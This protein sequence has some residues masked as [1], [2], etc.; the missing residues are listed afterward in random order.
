MKRNKL[1]TFVS[2]KLWLASL[3]DRVG[4]VLEVGEEPH[5]SI[6]KRVKSG[7]KGLQKG[8]TWPET[9]VHQLGLHA[10]SIGCHGERESP[11]VIERH[12]SPALGLGELKEAI[13][14]TQLWKDS[15]RN[16]D[17]PPPPQAPVTLAKD[18]FVAQSSFLHSRQPRTQ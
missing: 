9:S 18:H 15:L 7:Q 6:K 11:V 2:R 5:E 17:T 16:I 1:P 12:R 13:P 3:R 10:I 14:P 4:S 8:Q